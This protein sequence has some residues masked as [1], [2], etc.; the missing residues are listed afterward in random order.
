MYLKMNCKNV[1]VY[2]VILLICNNYLSNRLNSANATEPLRVCGVFGV[3]FFLNRVQTVTCFCLHVCSGFAESSR[4]C[5][6]GEENH[7]IGHVLNTAH[8][9]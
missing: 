8:L 5:K 6:Q 9:L 2:G 7:N 1:V 3:F 4:G